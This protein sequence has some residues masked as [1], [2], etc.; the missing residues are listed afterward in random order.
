MSEHRGDFHY[1]AFGVA[2]SSCLE[3]P[4]LSPSIPPPDVSLRYARVDA[5]LP[6]PRDRGVRYAAAPGELLLR[7]DGVARF[8]VRGGESIA[9][10]RDPVAGDADIRPFLLGSAFGALLHQRGTIALQGNVV[11]R[12]GIGVLILGKTATGK[13]TLAAALM[14]RGFSCVSDDLCALGVPAGSG[15]EAH[16]GCTYVRL[17][18]DSLSSLGIRVSNLPRVR[19]TLDR[20]LWTTGP[21]SSAAVSVT[22]A[23]VLSPSPSVA[24][25]RLDALD[26]AVRIR[27]LRDYTYRAEFL[28]G[29]NL[30]AVCFK[31]LGELGERLRLVRLTRPAR[32][33][34]AQDLADVVERA[35]RP[36][37]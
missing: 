21:P 18:S 34:S 8:L 22:H 9:I 37:F 25:P 28:R 1:Q 5:S 32:G 20:R 12:D 24:K 7:V 14:Q 35:L 16:T 3:C 11:A 33:C 23:F 2:L 13:S 17:W 29:L 26:T 6:A 36:G 30:V 31:Q 4:E 27:A 19:P 15:V 10:D